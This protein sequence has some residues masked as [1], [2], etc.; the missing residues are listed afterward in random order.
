LR[1]RY[2][3]VDFLGHPNGAVPT[4]IFLPNL[5]GNHLAISLLLDDIGGAFALVSLVGLGVDEEILDGEALLVLLI[6]NHLL[7]LRTLVGLVA[8]MMTLETCHGFSLLK[9]LHHVLTVNL[10]RLDNALALQS[11]KVP[12]EPFYFLLE[13]IILLD[14]EIIT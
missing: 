7:G 6:R 11:C 1:P 8:F 5:V 4:P 14:S 9:L 12:H 10:R 13:L 3:G 2:V